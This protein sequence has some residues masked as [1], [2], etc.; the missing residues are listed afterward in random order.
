[1]TSE[2]IL[3]LKKLQAAIT[4][5]GLGASAVVLR[6]PQTVLDTSQH[7]LSDDYAAKYE[8]VILEPIIRN[9]T[10]DLFASAFYNNAVQEAFKAVEQCV[11]D[12]SNTMDS[13]GT[14]LMRSVFN[15]SNPKLAWSAR[16][17]ISERD[18]HEGYQHIFAGAMMGVRNPTA[19]EFDWID[20]AETALD[21]IVFA[22][23]LVSKA[24]K[25]TSIE[26]E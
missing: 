25:A 14:V 20:N 3:R 11:R 26:P 1:M 5:E 12:K 9:V 2:L 22:Q 17:T 24:L 18:E 16:K 23:H 10:K 13:S 19:H 7:L 15:K 6:T 4:S 8:A 21:L